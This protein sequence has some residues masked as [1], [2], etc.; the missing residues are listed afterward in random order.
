M[1][2]ETADK[3]VS[4]FIRP[5]DILW[6]AWCAY[7]RKPACFAAM[8]RQLRTF[9]HDQDQAKAKSDRAQPLEHR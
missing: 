3:A 5:K 8:C 9:K 6:Q 7:P 2:K 4:L 1:N